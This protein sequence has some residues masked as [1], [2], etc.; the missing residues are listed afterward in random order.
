M[1]KGELSVGKVYAGGE[2]PFARD[3]LSAGIRQRPRLGHCIR[4]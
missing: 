1:K 4:N 2:E 3:V